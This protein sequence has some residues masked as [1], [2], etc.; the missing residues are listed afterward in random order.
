MGSMKK[1]KT[2]AGGAVAPNNSPQASGGGGGGGSGGHGSGTFAGKRGGS[3][4]K[5]ERSGPYPHPVRGGGTTGT[6]N[7]SGDR[8]GITKHPMSRRPT[9]A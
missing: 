4:S 1:G 6:G 3:M 5:E 9:P 7:T 2:L 8:A